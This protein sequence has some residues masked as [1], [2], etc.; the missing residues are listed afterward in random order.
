MWGVKAGL[1]GPIQHT[2]YCSSNC[3]KRLCWFLQKGVNTHSASQFLEY[4][5]ASPQTSQGAHFCPLPKVPTVSIRTGPLRN[6][7]RWLGRVTFS[8]TSH[9]WPGAYVSLT[10]RTHGTRMHYGEKASRWR[11]C[12]A[13]GNVLLGNLGSCYSCGCY[14]FT[15]HLRKHC[16]RCCRPFMTFHE[17]GIPWWQCHLSA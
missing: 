7:R 10:W 14:F 9:G 5:V 12:D 13:L 4:G 1:C 2:S 3:K 6:W 11:Q 8:F 16:C 15:C 17:N